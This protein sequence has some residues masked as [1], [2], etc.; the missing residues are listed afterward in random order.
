MANTFQDYYADKLVPVAFAGLKEMLLPEAVFCDS[1]RRNGNAKPRPVGQSPRYSAM[2]L[3][4]LAMQERL[5]RTWD[6][7]TEGVWECLFDWATKDARLG[8]TG[9]V[10]WAAAVK[11]HP[12]AA[13][14]AEN[15]IQREHEALD[16]GYDMGTMS[17]GWL[18]TGL[19]AAMQRN[20]G[21]SRLATIADGVAQRLLRN[22][23]QDT[24]LF[25][26]GG[27]ECRRN[28]FP[29]RQ[30]SR[31]GSFASQVYPVIG[32]SYYATASG[33]EEPL[34]L[35][36]Q[37]ADVLCR[38]Q[39]PDGQW[40]WIYDVGSARPTIRYPVYSVHQHSMGPMALLAVSQ[41]RQG[42]KDYS[43]AICKS[44]DWLEKHPEL[45]EETLFPAE[46]QIVWRAI[47]RDLPSQTAGFGLGRG[48]RLRMHLSA[49]TGMADNRPFRSGYV[50]DECRPY[51][52]GWILVAGAL[53]QTAAR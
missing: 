20:L 44:L 37:T 26:L 25:A 9:L 10:L 40:W 29:R 13:Q 39:G 43:A 30:S 47:Q 2:V 1:L 22:R 5:G 4:G 21:G 41:A 23:N 11:D 45:A 50:C 27:G 14:L 52:L 18:L 8:D 46:V 3:I 32:L 19:G 7:P 16:A 38:L 49:W 24:S 48:E 36:E 42:K 6:T 15:V 31:L 33:K 51:E 53:A 17:L 34:R 28:P 35:A 12:R